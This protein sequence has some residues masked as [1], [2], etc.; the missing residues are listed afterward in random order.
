[1]LNFS[2]PKKIILLVIACAIIIA[3]GGVFVYK[4]K[5]N[6]VAENPESSLPASIGNLSLGTEVLEQPSDLPAGLPEEGAI[7][8][9]NGGGEETGDIREEEKTAPENQ[10][11]VALF[12]GDKK[13]ATSVPENSNVYDLMEKLQKET[14]FRFSGK[15]YSGLGFFV[16]EINGIKNNPKDSQYWIY[17]VNGQEANLGISAMKVKQG[18]IIMWQYQ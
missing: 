13:Y 3:V 4:T 9:N 2:R 1:M 18:D 5:H 7:A 10:T 15:N 11:S 6:P 14:D 17:Y 16:E 8:Q 12:V